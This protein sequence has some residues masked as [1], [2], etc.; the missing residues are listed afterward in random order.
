MLIVFAGLPGVGKTTLS[1]LLAER[2]RA[3]YVRVDAVES[4]L[5][6]AGVV[7]DQ[8]AIGTAGYVVAN[9]VAESCLRAGLDVVVDAVNPVEAAREGW[10]ALAN[11]YN[12]ELLFVEVVCSD[13][14]RH[15]RQVEERVT[16]LAGWTQPDW[17]AVLDREYEPWQ[18]PRLVIDNVGD[19]ELSVNTILG[20]A[21]SR[22]S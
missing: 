1:Q 21:H 18:G 13:P 8:A 15:R 3:S 12:A 6:A 20:R 2:Q 17:Q 22:T 16:D 11:E 19:P 4:G 10:R 5:L 7:S 14:D 9:R